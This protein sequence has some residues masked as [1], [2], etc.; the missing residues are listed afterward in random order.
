[1]VD[2]SHKSK[3]MAE[4]EK[5]LLR[6]REMAIRSAE[7][8][9]KLQVS[10]AID[11]RSESNNRISESKNDINKSNQLIHSPEQEPEDEVPSFMNLWGNSYFKQARD[12]VRGPSFKQ[13]PIPV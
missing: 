13:V 7:R 9:N 6:H 10:S 11:R 1:M 5:Q 3:E 4:G 12:A 8:K 2:D